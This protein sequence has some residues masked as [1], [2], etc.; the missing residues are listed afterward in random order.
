MPPRELVTV[1]TFYAVQRWYFSYPA[2]WT[3][4]TTAWFKGCSLPLCHVDT[5]PGNSHAVCN[6]ITGVSL[7]ESY[8]RWDLP[9][10]KSSRCSAYS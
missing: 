8:E 3:I 9:F 2:L 1:T 7:S 5:A 6:R 4:L 10:A